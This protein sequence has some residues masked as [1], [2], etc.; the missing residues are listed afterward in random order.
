MSIDTYITIIFS[1]ITPFVFGSLF[2][3]IKK[4]S[5]KVLLI[6][7]LIFGATIIYKF[8][9]FILFS[10]EIILSISKCI[11][12]FCN[13]LLN[14]NGDN[15]FIIICSLY[16]STIIEFLINISVERRFKYTELSVILYF[17]GI[18]LYITFSCFSLI[19]AYYLLC[20]TNLHIVSYILFLTIFISAFFYKHILFFLISIQW[21]IEDW[22]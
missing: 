1:I 15:T 3:K 16:I 2:K 14:I 19:L 9:T 20:N 18:I 5:L 10:S 21:K 11:P 6:F 13:H 4:N 7:I 12:F 8:E 17:L 22:L